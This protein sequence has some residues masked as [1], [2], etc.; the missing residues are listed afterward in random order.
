MKIKLIII[1]VFVGLSFLIGGSLYSNYY[2]K[3]V[4]SSPIGYTYQTYW[5]PPNSVLIIED[6]SYKAALLAYYDSI[7]KNP[8]A[9]PI[10]KV[11]LKTLPQYE[12]VY[13][14]GYSEDSSLTDIVSYYNRGRYRGGSYLR[15][16]VDTRTLHK[17]PAKK[18]EK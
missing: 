13:I 6:L 10:I 15:G 16:W 14:M 2:H 1:L 11:P 3:K 4:K 5:G 17:N 9:N 18:P 7:L 8:E 12:P